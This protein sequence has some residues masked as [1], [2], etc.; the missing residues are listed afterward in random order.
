MAS[1]RT[2]QTSTIAYRLPAV[3][4]PCPTFML[5]T[6]QCRANPTGASGFSQDAHSIGYSKLMPPSRWDRP[7]RKRIAINRHYQ[8]VWGDWNPHRGEVPTTSG[9]RAWSLQYLHEQRTGTATKYYVGKS[10]SLEG[11]S[12]HI[13]DETGRIVE[14][15][16]TAGEL[17]VLVALAMSGC[18]WS[19]SA[20]KHTRQR[21]L[22]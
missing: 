8:T 21:L 2:P 15:S 3:S 17:R 19:A 16:Q 18:K 9:F 5:K 7:L 11:S 13:A 22:A 12:I 4:S 14:E 1:G 20:L 10:G 6:S